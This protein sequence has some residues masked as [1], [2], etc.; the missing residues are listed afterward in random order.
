MQIVRDSEDIENIIKK[1]S[2]KITLYRNHKNFIVEP[3]IQ[4]KELTV[5][6]IEDNKEFI[7]VEVT[8]ITYE[9][10]FFNYQAKYTEGFSKHIIPA[11]LDESIYKKC[12]KDAKI[13]HEIIGCN[14]VSRSDFI[15]DD[16]NKLYFLEINNQ[17]GLTPISLV[18][19]QLS[20]KGISFTDLIDRLIK[21]AKC[22]Q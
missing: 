20:S 4:G 5:T 3:Y 13:A 15:Y 19:E 16:N 2:D 10:I 18:P 1:S 9:N 22:R 12:L 7:P 8:E 14:G 21:L 11:L 6:V 17:P